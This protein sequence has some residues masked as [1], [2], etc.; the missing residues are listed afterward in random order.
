MPLLNKSHIEITLVT[1]TNAVPGNPS[2]TSVETDFKHHN[3]CAIQMPANQVT[4][5]EARTAII[6]PISC[7]LHY[8][9]RN[10]TPSKSATSTSLD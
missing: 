8:R 7:I 3:A 5:K 1:P 6:L 2:P 9:N 10:N 4:K